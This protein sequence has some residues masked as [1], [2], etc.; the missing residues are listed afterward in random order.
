MDKHEE[1]GPELLLNMMITMTAAKSIEF[2]V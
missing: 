2:T 1:V